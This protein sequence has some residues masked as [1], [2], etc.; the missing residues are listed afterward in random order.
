MIRSKNQITRIVRH[1]KIVSIL[2]LLDDSLEEWVGGD[3]GCEHEGFQSLFSWMIRSKTGNRASAQELTTFQSLFSWMIRS[4]AA[5]FRPF[6][7]VS[8]LKCSKFPH[9]FLHAKVLIPI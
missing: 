4:K 8:Q 9:E 2:V 6:S 5:R 3:P 1:R 7:A